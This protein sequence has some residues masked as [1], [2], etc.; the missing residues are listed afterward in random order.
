MTSGFKN[1]QYLDN[2]ILFLRIGLKSPKTISSSLQIMI[3]RAF[4]QFPP[5]YE[6]WSG[7][8]LDSFL[9]FLKNWSEWPRDN[10]LPFL[11]ISQNHQGT[12]SSSFWIVVITPFGQFPPVS[13]N[14]S[15]SPMDNFLPFLKIGQDSLGTISSHFWKMVRIA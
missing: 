13:K 11:K 8:P 9:L 15:E 1:S 7:N 4:R 10:F 2:F 14:W 5:I 3:R 12:I 6:K